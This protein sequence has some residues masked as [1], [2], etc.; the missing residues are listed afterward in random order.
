[1]QLAIIGKR[2]AGK[3]TLV[4][5][6]AGEKRVIVSEIAGT[7][8]DAVDVRFE[9]DGRAFVAIDTAGLRR[10][11]SFKERIEHF[12][13]DRCRAA[14]DRADVALLLIDATEAISQVDQQ[15]GMMVAESYKPV[16]IVVNKW[17]LAEGKPIV[18]GSGAPN[19]RGRKVTPEDYEQYI[20]TELKG[21][22]FAPIAFVSAARA[23][24]IAETINL[25]FELFEQSHARATT[26]K[27][28]RLV[29]DIV[30]RQGPS[31]KIGTFA[32]ILYVAQIATAPPTIVCVVNK[33]DLFTPNYQRFLINRFREEL[34]FGEV[35]IKLLIRARQRDEAIES[36]DGT[37]ARVQRKDRA[38]PAERFD[39]AAAYFDDDGAMVVGGERA[40]PGVEPEG[41]DEPAP[42]SAPAS[43]GRRS[44]RAERPAP[45]R[46]PRANPGRPKARS[47]QD[48]QRGKGG[49]RERPD[50]GGQRDQRGGND[51]RGRGGVRAR[52]P[53]RR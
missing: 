52:K 9:M 35:P 27:L 19:S 47:G 30:A 14:V 6:L 24:N 3:S 32:K 2:N 46:A 40:A 37:I 17:D 41:L 45:A 5:T 44:G 8:R 16:V 7:T 12:A 38:A 21:L 34:P 49:K 43:N 25:A 4:N 36:D 53:G 15:L 50:S 11:K 48:G 22:S 20:R 1:M 10:K 13:L 28:N 39:D 31:D 51:R 26:G 18:K 42:A 23:S 29:R 33:P